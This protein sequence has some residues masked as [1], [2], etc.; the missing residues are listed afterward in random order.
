[1][2]SVLGSPQARDLNINRQKR[3]AATPSG[4]FSFLGASRNYVSGHL[5][6]YVLPPVAASF[7]QSFI[8]Q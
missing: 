8:Y 5:I 2:I 4:L 7:D 1:M 6:L 3:P